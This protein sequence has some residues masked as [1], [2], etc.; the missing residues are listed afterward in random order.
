ME[1]DESLWLHAG[2]RVSMV[3]LAEF[4]GLPEAVLRE[5]VEFG[6]LQPAGRD[7][8]VFR[9]DCVMRLRTAARLRTDLELETP[10]LALALSFLERI[11]WLEAEVR[12]LD[13]QLS[14]PHH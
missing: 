3:E 2:G 7:Q 11:Q 12:R 4:S 8:Q 5:L 6:A 13:A 14:R 10:A 9:G 1:H